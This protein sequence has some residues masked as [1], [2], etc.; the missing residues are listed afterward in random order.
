ME[1]QFIETENIIEPAATRQD[2][3][4]AEERASWL[5]S[6]ERDMRIIAE[7]KP[8]KYYSL[9]EFGKELMAAVESKL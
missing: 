4:T 6:I 1:K 5:Q 7:D 3:L 2:D 8:P 9:D